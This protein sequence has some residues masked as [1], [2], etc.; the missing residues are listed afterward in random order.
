MG[1]PFIANVTPPVNQN[2]RAYWMIL[3]GFRLL[4]YDEKP[5]ARLPYL[6]DQVGA[7]LA[8]VSQVLALRSIGLFVGSLPGGFM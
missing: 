2:E 6:R 1:N 5:E 3:N 8:Q 4:V 7:N